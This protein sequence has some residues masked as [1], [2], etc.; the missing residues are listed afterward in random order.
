MQR[1]A[2]SQ[3]LQSAGSG[4][5]GL[6]GKR[7][8]VSR[9]VLL[10]IVVALVASTAASRTA[11]GEAAAVASPARF[12]K[13]TGF[14]IADPSYQ[15]YFDKRGGVQTFGYPV[16]REF[17]LLGF[18]VQIFQ[19]AIFQRYPDGHIQ[20]L[21]LLDSDLFPYSQV[22]GAVLPAADPTLIGTAPPVATDSYAS[23]VLSWIDLTAP[24]QWSGLPVGFHQT[25]VKTVAP[26][27]A[28]GD[29]T[30]NAGLIV[31]F[32]LEVWGLPTSRPAFDPNNHSVV[33]Q[34]F[35]RGILQFDAACGCTHGLLLADYF[36]AILLGADMPP[37]LLSSARD[38]AFFGQYQ[39][40]IPSWVV[41][42]ADLPNSDLTRAFEPQTDSVPTPGAPIQIGS[43]SVPAVNAESIAIVDETSGELL[44][45]KDPHRALPPASITKIFTSIVALEHGRLNQN[46]TVQYD[47]SQLADSTL[48]GI[49]PG[50]SYSLEDLLYGLMLPSGNDAALAIANAVGGSEPQFVGMMNAKAAELGLHD[51]HF[52]NP[53]GLDAPGHETSAYDVTMAARYGMTHFAEFPRLAS[54][55]S[56]QVNGTRSFTVYNLNRFL[57]SYPGADGVKIGYTDAAGKTIVA[58]ATRGGHRVY[59]A[60]MHCG[61]IVADT[62]PLFDWVFDNFSW[63]SN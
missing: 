26:S 43:A 45:G 21:N 34:R 38:S 5:V 46:V 39:S 7:G 29:N 2:P 59:V 36:K 63:P 27:T 23:R 53:H 14:A 3:I 4:N 16:S 57:R 52:V 32:D 10:L 51:S 49:H 1:L 13:E 47:E 31:G 11:A 41:R 24:D 20:L 54:A 61:D 8:R 12:F 62:A 9:L 6:E 18:P 22:N 60:L 56:W 17:T 33:Y 28:L 35:E 19:R 50:E 42:P 48:M 58:S 15:N 55:R 44:Y 25:F 30:A 37:D 40:G